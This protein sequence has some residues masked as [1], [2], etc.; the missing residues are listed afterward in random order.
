MRIVARLIGCLLLSVLIVSV[1]SSYY[2]AERERYV[3]R[4]ELEKRADVLAESLQARVESM[5]HRGDIAAVGKL[6][7]R[8]ADK[9][10]LAGIVVYGDGEKPL[11]ISSSLAGLI[12]RKPET[13]S[14]T[15][16]ED[17]ARGQFLRLDGHPVH[18]RAVPLHED[19]RV[20]GGLLVVHDANN[21]VAARRQA[22][23]DMSVRLLA[24]M[25]L[26]V[27]VTLVMFQRSVVKPI[28]RTAAWMREL[29]HGGN[30]G[31]SG[32]AGSDVLKPLANEAH[33][34]A[35]S[36]AEARASAEQE[37]RLREAAESSWTAERLAVSLRTR[38]KGSRL[39]VVS[40]REPYMDIRKGNTVQTIVPASGLVTALEPILRAC[41]G[42]WVAHGSGNADAETVDANFC[43]RVPPEDPHYTLRRVW[44]SRQEEER[45]YYGFSNE[46][47][48]PLCHIAHTRPT[49]RAAD[50]EEYK[51]INE[52]FANA[53]WDEMRDVEQ[54]IVIVQDYHFALL[55]RMLKQRRPDAR[56]GLFWHI[57]WPNPEAFGICP[58]Q[59]EL[60]DGMLGADLVGFHI[61]AHCDNF[62]ETV[63]RVLESRIEW[64]RRNVNRAE[65]MTMVR[66]F[67]ISIVMPHD[68]GYSSEAK[69]HEQQAAL[70]ND[71]GVDAIYM[72]VGVDRLDYTKGIVERLLGVERFLEKYEQYQG[73]FC[74]VQIGAPS[75]TTIQRYHDFMD[76][77]AATA[78][79]INRRFRSSKWQPVVFRNTHHTHA[80]LER[81]YRAADVCLVTSL[82][83][84]MNLVAKE[85]IASRQD[86]DGVL[87]LSPFTG[88]ARE[89]PDAL[90]VN[91]YDTEKLADAIYQALEMDGS[92]RQ[93]RMRRMRQVVR[94][95][96]VYRWAANLIGDLCEVRL[97]AVAPRKHAAKAL[98]ASVAQGVGGEIIVEKLVDDL[99]HAGAM[100]AGGDQ[101]GIPLDLR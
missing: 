38:L 98:A 74:F 19:D 24:Q 23:R 93:A 50:F 85:Y 95:H 76:E 59:R 26:I 68:A 97:D 58:W 78:E 46:G 60:L 79:R 2:Q 84:G 53:L 17:A 54:P 43:V 41:D 86:D 66:P 82:H 56:V 9:Q 1:L 70:L 48:W 35:R 65:H 83:D 25:L 28:A 71:L 40:N 37:A 61:Q 89:L 47:L 8:F 31:V 64:D 100:A 34:F 75:R 44:L 87:V 13:L 63:D 101:V 80:E 99:N 4:R 14:R 72:G 29:R 6:A 73:R 12:L 11:A 91:P 32:L 55:P 81:F 90:I 67:P 52:R 16:L 49:F 22:W 62:L 57:P 21:I 96:N 39:F 30:P 15:L 10:Q 27:V 42:T 45:Y 51:R 7:Q 33:S 5:L 20:I 18:F 77:V 94:E 3:L 36:L 88:A 92:E 69:P